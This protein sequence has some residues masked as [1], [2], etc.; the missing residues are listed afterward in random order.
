M[1]DVHDEEY[2]NHMS[3]SLINSVLK[4]INGKD[5]F[6]FTMIK[7]FVVDNQMIPW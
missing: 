3:V 5:C 4:F 2:V 7:T 1:V 6:A